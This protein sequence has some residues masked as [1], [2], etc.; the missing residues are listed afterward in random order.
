MYKN[1]TCSDLV[2]AV[3]GGTG[4][5][6]AYLEVTSES[7]LRVAINALVDANRSSKTRMDRDEIAMTVL[8]K[9]P[10]DQFTNRDSAERAVDRSYDVAD[11][12]LKRSKEGN[13]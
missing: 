12:M 2:D 10:G 11:N 1:L 3:Q 8:L 7:E 13:L 5:L 9:I 6:D 4:D